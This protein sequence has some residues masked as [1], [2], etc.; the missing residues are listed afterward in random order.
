M[1]NYKYNELSYA[2]LI[3]SKGFQTKHIPTELRLLVLYYRDVL[4]LKP[5]EREERLNEFCKNNVSNFKKEKLFKTINT[6]LNS[7][8]KK[9][10]KLITIEKI[11]ISKTEID[12]INLLDIQYEY[13][14]VM[15]AFLVQM[16]LNKIVY[17]YK[18]EKEYSSIYFK[19][20]IKKYNNIKKM[21]N[22]PTKM[23]INDEVINKLEELKLITILHKG[24]ILLDY[25]N[26]C[27]QGKEIVITITDFE[28]IGLYLDY[29]NE[30]KGVKECEN[31]CGCIIKIKSNKQKYC[32]NCAKE[33]Q[34]Q[35]Q[36]DSM[37]KNRSKICEVLENPENMH[38]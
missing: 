11:D 27:V 14:K 13:K 3:Y 26:N 24:A 32:D 20:G 1:T 23:L 6:A 19:G 37:K 22:I 35:W 7:A 33:M 5:K 8:L 25:I 4:K 17:E 2:E 9:D 16:K 36:R 12:Y 18:Y 21:A 29:Y 10:Q 15:F 30:V 34:L 31:N 28:N 38:E